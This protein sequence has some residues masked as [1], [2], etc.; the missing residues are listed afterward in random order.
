[1]LKKY[2]DILGGIITAAIL[3]I[4]AEFKL[5]R[6]QL[7]YSIVILMLVSIG[8][9]RIIKQAIDKNK[10]TK[11]KQ[12]AHNIIDDMVDTQTPVK[13]INL[14]TNP[15]R[16]GERLGKLILE[17]IKRGKKKMKK[18]KVWFDKFKGY[19]LTIALGILTVVENCGGFIN[20]MFNDALTIKGVE[21]LPI[22][23]LV[24]AIVV[25]ILSNGYTKED[26]ERIKALFTKKPTNELVAAQIKKTLKESEL[27]LKELNKS[28]I[29]RETELE[30]LNTL[31]TSAKNTH[32]A[33]EEMFRMVP[34]LATREEVQAAA[35]EVVNIEARINDKQEEIDKINAQ[36]ATLTTKI[37][38][39]KIQL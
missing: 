14:A 20:S 25:G 26:R 8:V 38:A 30:N 2:W 7:I 13:S 32:E 12:R 11:V 18:L 28:L 1:V 23:T 21:V 37:N 15:T 36:I 27:Q 5:D 4:L 22:I 24:A 29:I 3:S 39:L 31:Y 16:E 34:Q 9:W 35:N 33:K 17:T 6:I 19:I 10:T